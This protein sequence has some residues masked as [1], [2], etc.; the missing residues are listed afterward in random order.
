MHSFQSECATRLV[1]GVV[2]SSD[3]AGAA[4]VVIV[5]VMV[6]VIMFGVIVMALVVVIVVVISISVIMTITSF[7][8]TCTSTCTTCTSTYICT[9]ASPFKPSYRESSEV[10]FPFFGQDILLFR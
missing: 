10:Q 7:C 1:V 2:G 6:G 9:L 8:P 5:G 3:A 4:I